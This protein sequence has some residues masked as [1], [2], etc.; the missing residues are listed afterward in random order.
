MNPFAGNESIQDMGL[1]GKKQHKL[2]FMYSDLRN[3][4]R[5]TV[6]L[7]RMNQQQPLTLRIYSLACVIWFPETAV[8]LLLFADRQKCDYHLRQIKKI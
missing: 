7:C 6:S 2:L 5:L 8:E 4:I 3:Y 1:G